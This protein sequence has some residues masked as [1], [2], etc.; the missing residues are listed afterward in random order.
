MRLFKALL[1][2]TLSISF[3]CSAEEPN[4]I[5]ELARDF[6]N[7]DY[8]SQALSMHDVSQSAWTEV[9]RVLRANSSTIMT[10]IRARAAHF[11]PNPFDTPFQPHEA[12]LVVN[13]V[14]YDV[15]AETLAQ[16][17]IT[18]PIAVK[19]MYY[20]IHEQHADKF[21]KCFG[22]EGSGPVRH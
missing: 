18:D 16:F 14:L 6:F 9:N 17:N 10:R 19:E 1:T 5:K 4:C 22:K 11:S 2:L 20:Y 21:L 8:V 7:P 15:F 13:G 3:L 12:S